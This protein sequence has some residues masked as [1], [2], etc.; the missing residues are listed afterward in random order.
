MAPGV[1]PSRKMRSA[2]AKSA[3]AAGLVAG[4]GTS[5]MATIS[6]CPAL[7]AALATVTG[8]LRWRRV[9]ARSRQRRRE[10]PRR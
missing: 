9:E 7:G 2:A 1:L 4:V 10:G 5:V 3:A 6:C 8:R